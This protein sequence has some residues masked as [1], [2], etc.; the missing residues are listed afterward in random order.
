MTKEQY[1]EKIMMHDIVSIFLDPEVHATME[2][3]EAQLDA[4]RAGKLFQLRRTH[5]QGAKTMTKEQ[6]ADLNATIFDFQKKIMMHDI[7]SMD[8]EVR[9][10]MEAV[11]A[12]L[13]ALRTG[14][15]FQ[16]R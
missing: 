15:L 14:N 7:A 13:D 4:L 8:P 10:T 16:L 6:Y 11:E 2:A 12:Q 9:A 3:V 5:R 1:A